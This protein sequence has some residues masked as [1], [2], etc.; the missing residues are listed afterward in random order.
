MQENAFSYRKNASESETHNSQQL[1]LRRRKSATIGTQG[2]QM[3]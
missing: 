2:P 3:N 1:P